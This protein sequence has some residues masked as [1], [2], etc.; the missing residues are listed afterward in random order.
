MGFIDPR[1]ATYSRWHTQVESTILIGRSQKE[2]PDQLR[3]R[4]SRKWEGF[5]GRIKSLPTYISSR[6]QSRGDCLVMTCIKPSL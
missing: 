3:F 6:I 5:S 1:I 4:S 2:K